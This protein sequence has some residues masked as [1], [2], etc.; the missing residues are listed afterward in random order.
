MLCEQHLCEFVRRRI[1]L[2]ISGCPGIKERKRKIVFYF[3]L[4]WFN[5]IVRPWSYHLQVM[6]DSCYCSEE[7]KQ[8]ILQ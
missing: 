4:N 2:F 3:P 8:G 5:C 6:T 7:E 1:Y